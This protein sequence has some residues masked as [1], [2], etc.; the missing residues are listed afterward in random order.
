MSERPHS[1]SVH[2]V[3]PIR[4]ADVELGDLTVLVGPQGTGK[5]LFLQLLRLALD[6]GYVL[7]QM[8]KHGLQWNRDDF[9]TFLD[10]Y[11][12]EGMGAAWDRQ[13]SKLVFNGRELAPEGLITAK[14]RRSKEPVV[15][16]IPAQRVL[17]LANGWPRPFQGFAP[18]DPFTLRDF[19]ETFRLL[20]E[21]EF[22]RLPVV[23]PKSNRLKAAYRDL[24]SQHLFCGFS[25]QVDRYGSQNRLVLT[26]DGSPAIPY[27]VWSAGQREFVP[28]LMGLYWLLPPAK[29][30]R[31]GQLEWAIL[32][33]PEM[34]LHD[35]ALGAVLLL[36]LELLHRGYRVCI[37][38]HTA[39][40]LV[41]I[42][43]IRI[44][45]ERG[46]SI[47][48][49]VRALGMGKPDKSLCASVL[50]KDYRAYLFSQEGSSVDISDLSL[51][52]E[53][54]DQ[55]WGGLEMLASRTNRFV[56]DLVSSPEDVQ[57]RI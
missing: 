17:S 52:G 57:E 1:M 26:R 32:E 38:T 14:G 2:H 25:L 16:Y 13:H 36:I 44:A 8:R 39:N 29:I 35:M 4:R 48:P 9:S 19:S 49:L 55:V 5:S 22:N 50:H 7:D 45:R 21:Q 33:E 37:S 12:G 46:A 11:L 30:T 42:W 6:T 51:E 40:V 18:G 31:R 28:L 3:G 47:E 10:A 56:M 27:L 15:F 34:G 54:D 24:L 20:M 41:L 23:F 53:R 43:G